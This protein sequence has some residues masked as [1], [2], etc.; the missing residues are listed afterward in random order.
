MHEIKPSTLKWEN[1]GRKYFRKMLMRVGNNIKKDTKV[2]IVRILP[3]AIVKPHYHA[4]QDELEYILSGSGAVKSKKQ[5]IRL[6][7]G[8]IFTVAPNEIHEVKAGKNGLLLLVTK[9]NYSD[10]TEWLE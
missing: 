1:T 2:E 7:P 10:D 8:S 4:G 9:A 6:M 3:N 5:L